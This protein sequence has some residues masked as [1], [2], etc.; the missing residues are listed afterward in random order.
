MNSMG[1]A[2]FLQALGWAVL[3]SLWQMALLWVIYQLITG[4]NKTAKSS[5]K[6]SLASTLLISG[7]AWFVYTFLSALTTKGSAS[8]VFSSGWAVSETNQQLNEW[9]EKTLPVASITYLLLLIFPLLHFTRNYRY[10]QA[11][12]RF[13]LTKADVKW[14][15]FVKKVAAHMG[16]K[17]NVQVWIS[18]LVSSPVT[19]GFLKPVIL[20]PLA[21]VNGLSPAQLEAV[22]LHELSH[23]RRNDYFTNLIINA[24]QAILYFNP[25]VKAFV[26]SVEREREKSCDEMV[27][28]F[29]Y[30]PHGY[31]SALLILEKANRIPKAFAI[32]ASGKKN[33][34]LSRVEIIMG[35]DKKPV[36][37]FNKLAGLL[38]GL[39]A[40]IALNAIV[41]LNRPHHSQISGKFDQLASPFAFFTGGMQKT[42]HPAR[43]TSAAFVNTNEQP[44]VIKTT[45]VNIETTAPVAN[46]ARPIA[47]KRIS[48]PRRIQEG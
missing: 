26:K 14:R 40:V 18:G 3:N 11:I 8:A 5:I 43:K 4:I 44:L 32:A 27:M 39:L 20:F 28:Q 48:R 13:E 16:I 41:I 31:A 30:D 46:H 15:M 24:I 34:L 9:L 36:I 29:Q 47:F 19:V 25:F 1:Q 10:V 42:I 6:S 22:L 23:I 35:V 7:F 12:R 33:D 21:A 37:S 45:T 2:N 17:K 38:A